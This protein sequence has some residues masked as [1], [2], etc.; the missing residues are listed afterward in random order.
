MYSK[1]IIWNKVFEGS[2]K[3]CYISNVSYKLVIHWLCCQPFS[4][5]WS[6]FVTKLPIFQLENRLLRK[7]PWSLLR[8]MLHK[9]LK[10]C[11]L[12]LC[13]L[14]SSSIVLTFGLIW[15]ITSLF[16]F[17]FISRNNCRHLTRFFDKI[18]TICARRIWN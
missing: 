6:Y 15:L 8:L 13:C 5:F 11:I 1:C 2:C 3:I 12:P 9:L 7:D 18:Q 4:Q 16:L 17:P 10:F 14:T